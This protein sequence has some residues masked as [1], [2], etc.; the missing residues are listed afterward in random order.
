MAARHTLA[1]LE[2][3]GVPVAVV[4]LESGLGRRGHHAVDGAADGA[5][6]PYAVN[7]FHINPLEASAQFD[8]RFRLWSR[9][10][11][12]VM[13]P[14][15]E[16]SRLPPSWTP[17]LAAMD[18][19]L[20]PSGFVRDAVETCV[21]G[22]RCIDY[23]QLLSLPAGIRPDRQRW[24]F[25]DDQF[26]VVSA[27][28]V[29]SVIE[30]KN[31]F[32]MVEAFLRA[33]PED[34]DVRLVLKVNYSPERGLDGSPGFVALR[35]RVADEPR[36]RLMPTVLPYDDVL[37]LYASADVVA[38]LHRSEGLGLSLMEAMVLGVPVL[39]TGYSGNVDFMT[40]DN[41]ML[42]P[43][44]LIDVDTAYRGYQQAA[45]EGAQWAEP[46]LDAAAAALRRLHDD[47]DLRR[48]LVEQAKTDVETRQR[49]AMD[50]HAFGE[51]RV[52]VDDPAVWAAHR[53]RRRQLLRA[54][55][56]RVH[57]RTVRQSKRVV[58]RGLRRT[59]LRRDPS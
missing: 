52:L 20:A 36:V 27:F 51:L 3:T 35:D 50:G 38:S 28:D 1:L 13:V 4:D 7:L 16:L 59:G 21:P 25:A 48:R 43:Y 19:V 57:R 26:V 14:Y 29:D 15:W 5:R 34:A 23:P 6:L 44:R 9:D 47:G 24:G 49:Q 46:D 2:T 31:P 56:T 11:L 17:V 40:E 33:F 45:E 12:N 18:I 58:V 42:I 32:G 8:R 22:V 10:R 30:R 37:S 53:E 39:A 55:A 41:S 54:S